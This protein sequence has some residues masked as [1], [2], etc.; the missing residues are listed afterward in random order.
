MRAWKEHVAK[1]VLACFYAVMRVSAVFNDVIR[2]PL[3][4]LVAC[5]QQEKFP[6]V[7]GVYVGVYVCVPAGQASPVYALDQPF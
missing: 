1:E 5:F 6:G 7:C 4:S 2:L 3:S